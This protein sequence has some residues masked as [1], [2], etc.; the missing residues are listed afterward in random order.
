MKNI[1]LCGFMG[2]GK[3]T[4][5]RVLAD[6]AGL[7]YVDMDTHIESVAHMRVDEIF[8]KFGEARFRELETEA[9]RALS[10]RQGL[11]ISTGGGAVLRPENTAAFKQGGRIVMIDVPLEVIKQRLLGD[12]TRP[13]LNR[14]DRDA[15]MAELFRKRIPVYLSVAD[16]IVKNERNLPAAN[17][18]EDIANQLGLG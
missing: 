5:G 2:C 15:A 14:E 10:R 6:R 11:V 16:L 8:A 12:T 1:V 3:S 9:A 17:V 13:L 18:A 7:E 4:V